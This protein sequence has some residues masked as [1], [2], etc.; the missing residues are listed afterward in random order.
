LLAR[1][2]DAISAR[3]DPVVKPFEQILFTEAF[4]AA[5]DKL[6]SAQPRSDQRA[7][8]ARAAEGVNRRAS[9]F[10]CQP[11]QNDGIAQHEDGIVARNIERDKFCSRCGDVRHQPPRARHH[12][13][14]VPGSSKNAHKLNGRCIR[15]APIECGYDHKHRSRGTRC[16]G[17]ER[18]A[19][20]NVV[21][22]GMRTVLD[23]RCCGCG[24]TRH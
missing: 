1:S 3:H 5:G 9:P 24:K 8:G 22:I 13:A 16:N 23:G 7:P 10:S 21:R 4:V 15:S 18:L 20:H 6:N 14:R 12:D 2:Y 11:R 17:A 19:A